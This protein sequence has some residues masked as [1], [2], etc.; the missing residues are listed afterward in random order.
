VGEQSANHMAR[1]TKLNWGLSLL[2]RAEVKAC[3]ICSIPFLRKF[4]HWVQLLVVPFPSGEPAVTH[5]A[6]IWQSRFRD[7]C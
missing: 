4:E 3:S 1:C 2:R 6:G 5:F 7:H